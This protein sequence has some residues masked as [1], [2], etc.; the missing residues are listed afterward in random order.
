MKLFIQNG[1][2]FFLILLGIFGSINIFQST[3]NDEPIHYSLQYHE[4]TN[5]TSKYNGII[6]GTSHA[7]HSIQPS[8]L[9]NTG[10]NFYNLA[11]NGSSPEFYINW[12]TELFLKYH[13]RVDYCIISVDNFFFSSFSW[14]MFEQDSEFFPRSSLIKF[15]LSKNKYDK[16]LLFLNSIP[17]FKYRN[18]F[19]ASLK[20]QTGDPIYN[21]SEYDRGFIPYEI[22]Y[23][24]KLFTRDENIDNQLSELQQNSFIKLIELLQSENVKIIIVM[25]PEYSLDLG[26]YSSLKKFI[27]QVSL[28]NNIPFYDF[29]SEYSDP[30]LH[31]IDYFSD[32]AH[33]NMKGSTQFSKKLSA[34]I[35]NHQ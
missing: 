15:L 5:K 2:I 10:I 19:K 18:R 24:Q 17:A 13:P 20:L 27:S 31:K 33:M 25:P 23:N 30:E 21:K 28:N 22:A 1:L 3:Y 34:V 9:D 32:K 7:T 6:I 11:L 8:L 29:N 12:Y 4:T 35:I 16:S 14:R 26:E